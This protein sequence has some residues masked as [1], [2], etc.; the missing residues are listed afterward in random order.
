MAFVYLISYLL[1]FWFILSCLAEAHPL[2]AS[3][4][5]VQGKY[6]IFSFCIS[7]NCVYA[8]QYMAQN[9]PSFR[10]PCWKSFLSENS[11]DILSSA[12]EK[13]NVIVT[14]C[15]V[16]DGNFASGSFYA[17]LIISGVSLLHNKM[18]L[19]GPLYVHSILLHTLRWAFQARNSFLSSFF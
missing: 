15:C 11:D 1:L 12:W 18:P 16:C 3:Q 14:P 8:I 19:G 6:F 13:P 5:R 7:K 4:G 2:A 9:Y 10:N 17:L